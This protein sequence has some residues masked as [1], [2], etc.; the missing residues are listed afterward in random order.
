MVACDS[1][2]D[3]YVNAERAQWL[4]AGREK[5]LKYYC[6]L[7]QVSHRATSDSEKVAATVWQNR[8]PKLASAPSREQVEAYLK[9][10]PGVSVPA[11]TAL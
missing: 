7:R 8:M 6:R 1:S 11:V 3:V 2:N 9:G 4:A 10:N 5:C